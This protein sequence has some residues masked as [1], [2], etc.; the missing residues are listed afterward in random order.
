VPL[1]AG[2]LEP[3]HLEQLAVDRLL[4]RL[5]DW[6]AE[7]GQA[8]LIALAWLAVELQAVGLPVALEAAAGRL[9]TEADGAVGWIN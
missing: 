5:G 4:E 3:L 1:E 2:A 6:Q 7:Q 8:F 9:V